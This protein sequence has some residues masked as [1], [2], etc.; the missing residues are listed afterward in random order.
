[1]F[2]Y[3][4]T[5]GRNQGDTPMS[6]IARHTFQG[7]VLDLIVTTARRF[8]DTEDPEVWAVESWLGS[9]QWQG[10]QEESAHFQ[11]RTRTE[12]DFQLVFDL[13]RWLSFKAAEYKQD[14]IAFIEGRSELIEPRS[15]DEVVKLQRQ[16]LDYGRALQA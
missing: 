15:L 8:M 14:A 2:T 5:I 1:M 7:D 16:L 9:A 10:V 12:L 11:L 6:D 13:K 4:I 3:D